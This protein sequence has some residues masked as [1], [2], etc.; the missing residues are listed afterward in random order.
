MRVAGRVRY[1]R[2]RFDTVFDRFDTVFD[3]I[4]HHDDDH[5]HD[6]YHHDNH[7]HNDCYDHGAY[8]Y[9]NHD[10]YDNDYCHD[11]DRHGN[12]DNFDGVCGGREPNRDHNGFFGNNVVGADCYHHDRTDHTYSE[13]GEQARTERARLRRGQHGTHR[14]DR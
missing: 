2:N 6:D 7:H 5:D 11:Y 4:D 8:H 3:R 13:F 12:H 9:H 10:C 14:R 1:S